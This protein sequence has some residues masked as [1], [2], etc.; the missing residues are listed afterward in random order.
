MGSKVSSNEQMPQNSSCFPSM[1]T[2]SRDKRHE[3][4]LHLPIHSLPGPLLSQHS[5]ASED[6]FYGNIKSHQII[7]YY[8]F[9]EREMVGEEN[10]EE[11]RERKEIQS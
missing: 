6:A 3:H 8:S 2:R 11:R 5:F 1:G 9:S 7:L 4:N 10:K